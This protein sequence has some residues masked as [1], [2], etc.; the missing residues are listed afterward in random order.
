MQASCRRKRR[1]RVMGGVTDALQPGNG[2]RSRE[3]RKKAAIQ[4]KKKNILTPFCRNRG[5]QHQGKVTGELFIIGG[6]KRKVDGA[7][8]KKKGKTRTSL[9]EKRRENRS[10]RMF[11]EKRARLPKRERKPAALEKR[12]KKATL[13]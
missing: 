2:G 12:R 4:K 7:P 13:R 1:V 11:I 9:K 3:I 8:E 6:R 5:N 10:E